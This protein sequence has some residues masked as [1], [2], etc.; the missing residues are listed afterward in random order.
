MIE[1]ETPLS[2][3]NSVQNSV[4]EASMTELFP[5]LTNNVI[6]NGK[7][8]QQLIIS[9]DSKEAMKH[10]FELLNVRLEITKSSA[11]TKMD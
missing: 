6:V 3:N 9:D 4:K 11:Y 2:Q 5:R 7:Q 10:A 1:L 8:Q